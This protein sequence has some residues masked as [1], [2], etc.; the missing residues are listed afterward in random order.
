MVEDIKPLLRL[1]NSKIDDG[2]LASFQKYYELLIEWNQ[3]MNLTAITEPEEVVIKH[4]YDSLTPSFY[5][6]FNGQKLIDIGAGA[7]FP[8]IPLKICFPELQITLLDSLNKRLIFLEEVVNHLNLKNVNLVHG[9]A[10]DYG[11]KKEFRQ[12]YDLVISRAVA[13]LNIIS[14]LSLP[15]V[16]VGGVMI[17]LKGSNIGE[18]LIEAHKAI[19]LLGGQF[20][21]T[22]YL[23]LPEG[24]GQRNIVFINKTTNTP[25]KY[26]RKPGVPNKNPII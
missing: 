1:H 26:P 25:D 10:E 23:E 4:F 12:E 19:T 14:E 17:S 6:D 2:Q 21:E 18:E 22:N 9:R 15:F 11:N 8:S 20:K 16:K 3:Q 13:R 24:Y 7:G 5:F